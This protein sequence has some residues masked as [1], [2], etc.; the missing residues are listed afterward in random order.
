[1]ELEGLTRYDRN[2]TYTILN[3]S[4]QFFLF[5]I[6]LNCGLSFYEN[7]RWRTVWMHKL[8]DVGYEATMD[9]QNILPILRY[10]CGFQIFSSLLHWLN[11]FISYY[12][13]KIVNYAKKNNFSGSAFIPALLSKL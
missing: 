11:S 5:V 2:F 6:T 10:F 13:S 7:N 9:S 12:M 8:Y 1:M 4:E 3:F